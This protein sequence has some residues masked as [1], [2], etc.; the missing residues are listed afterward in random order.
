MKYA[1]FKHLLDHGLELRES[2][3]FYE[4]SESIQKMIKV[5]PSL[6][7]NLAP[8]D[9]ITLKIPQ[10]GS[11]TTYDDVDMIIRKTIHVLSRKLGRIM[12]C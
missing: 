3:N 5:G 1:Q 12:I 7:I 8:W 6:L 11:V 9:L 2:I 10:N 4:T